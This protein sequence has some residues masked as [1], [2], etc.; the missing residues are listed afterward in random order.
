MHSHL[1]YGVDDGCADLEQTLAAIRRLRQAGFVGSICTP[2][3]WYQLFPHNTPDAIRAGVD[4]L[5]QEIAAAG[6]DYQIWPGGEVRIDENTVEGFERLGVPTLA[7]SRCVLLD[8][9]VDKW[10]RWMNRTFD[11]LIEHG[12]QPI[13]AHPERLKCVGELPRRL[14]DLAQRGVWLQGN[15]K[16]LTG[17][18]GFNANELV[19]RFLAEGRYR[20][21]ALDTHRPD[22]LE[23]RLDGMALFAAEFGD[24]TLARMTGD[25]VRRDFLAGDRS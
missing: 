17:Q 25:A 14:D 1:L 18:E 12:Y 13:L 6:E 23:V 5:R 3:V 10:P 16:C 22:T 15:F 20:F 9:W 2:H 4:R 7:D 21:M 24:D 11:W 8:A 19:R